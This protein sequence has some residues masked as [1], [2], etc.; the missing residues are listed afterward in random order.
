MLLDMHALATAGVPYAT[1]RTRYRRGQ[2]TITACDVRTRRILL[3]SNEVL[4]LLQRD[5]LKRHAA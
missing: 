2:F 1:L 5:E 4:A 3:D